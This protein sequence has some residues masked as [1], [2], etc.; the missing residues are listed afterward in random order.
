LNAAISPAGCGKRPFAT[1]PATKIVSGSL[2]N[3]GDL[4]WSVSLQS[5][6]N[7]YCGGVLINDQWVLTAAHCFRFVNTFLFLLNHAQYNQ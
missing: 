6:G 2:T 5:F 7:H 4:S 1:S 3:N